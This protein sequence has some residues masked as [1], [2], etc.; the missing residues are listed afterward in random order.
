M[1][2]TQY[3]HYIK[4]TS[5]LSASVNRH[6]HTHSDTDTDKPIACMHVA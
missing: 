2:G 1:H 4:I 6:T 3:T 5:S